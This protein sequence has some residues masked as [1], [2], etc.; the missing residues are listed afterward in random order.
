MQESW[1]SFA[2]ARTNNKDLGSIKWKER[3]GKENRVI[4]EVWI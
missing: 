4:G 1:F 2:S 3:K